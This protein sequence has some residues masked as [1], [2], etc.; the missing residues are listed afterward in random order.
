M[1]TKKEKTKL[2]IDIDDTILESS[3]AVIE[4]LNKKYGLNKKYE[5]L[6]DWEY[7]SIYHQLT[8]EEV[9]QIYN[10]DEFFEIV[11]IDEAFKKF[12]EKHKND[13]V[14]K[15]V[16]KGTKKNL[17]KKAKFIKENLCGSNFIPCKFNEHENNFDKSDIDMSG[18][19]QIDDRFDCMEK[20]GANVK[21]LLTHGREFTWNRETRPLDNL[22][23]VK[24][25]DE[26]S[27]ILEFSL[28]CNSFMDRCF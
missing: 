13:F 23:I 24:N 7:R 26:I 4:I 18:G 16:S 2:F 11:K 28:R 1:S 27:Q 22:Y 17:A 9:I 6:H 8:K 20:T 25:W 21:I 14:F 15:F 5:D 19:I 12:Y 3:K 10:S